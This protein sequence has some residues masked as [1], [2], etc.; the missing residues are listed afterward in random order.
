M[1]LNDIEINSEANYH[2]Y[3]AMANLLWDSTLTHK[4]TVLKGLHFWMDIMK[5]GLTLSSLLSIWF[6]NGKWT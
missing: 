4:S 2:H 5:F 3:L 6:C 1:K